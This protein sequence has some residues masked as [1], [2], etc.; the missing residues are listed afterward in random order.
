M[1][2]SRKLR[3]YEI[4]DKLTDNTLGIV[5]ARSEREA[6]N[7]LS[8]QKSLPDRVHVYPVKVTKKKSGGGLF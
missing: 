8:K 7:K 2:T 1:A 3:H 5:R 4:A 6:V